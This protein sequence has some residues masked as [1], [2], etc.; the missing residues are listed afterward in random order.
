MAPF[1]AEPLGDVRLNLTSQPQ[2]ESAL[3]KRL[4]VPTD[5]CQRHWIARKRHGNRCADFELRS[6]F[7]CQKQWEERVV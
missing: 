7:C 5:V 6:M 1:H 4:Q 3:R 2:D